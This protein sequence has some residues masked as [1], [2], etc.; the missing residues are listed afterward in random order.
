MAESAANSDTVTR[1]WLQWLIAPV[2]WFRLFCHAMKRWERRHRPALILSGLVL[3]FSICYFWLSIAICIRSG[4]AG[5]LY[6]L[7][8]GGTVTDRVYGEG[9]HLIFPWNEMH[10]YKV[11][12]QEQQHTVEL[13]TKHGMKMKFRL[14]IRYHPEYDLLGVLHKRVGP[15]YVTKIVIPV[16]VSVLRTHVGQFSA[17]EVYTTKRSILERIFLEAV[18]QV[19][20]NYVT[21]NGV[22]IRSI[23]LPP[24]I[25]KAVEAKIE[26]QH[27]AEAYD[28]RL[29]KEQKEAKRKEIE[30]GGFKIYNE[31]ISQSLNQ[32][33][34]KWKGIQATRELA[35]SPNTKVIVIGNGP[36]GL[37]IILGAEK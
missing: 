10:V 4:E 22:I 16:V 36:E 7:F 21:I 29:Q 14:S 8:G 34:L 27:I 35:V 18:E 23:D 25:L 19:T 5:V 32:D 28:Y 20:L 37:P 1:L 12:V 9:L 2:K 30:A 31:T 11:R 3:L 15:E 26:Q 17:E 33:I 24:R 6:R 13:L